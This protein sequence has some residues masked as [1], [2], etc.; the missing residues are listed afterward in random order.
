MGGGGMSADLHHVDTAVPSRSRSGTGRIQEEA[1]A[2]ACSSA[3][4]EYSP[5]LSCA[6]YTSRSNLLPLPFR[7]SF[8][9]TQSVYPLGARHSPP[10]LCLENK[11]TRKP[12]IQGGPRKADDL[13]SS[14]MIVN[15]R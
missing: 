8:V 11:L 15:A 9:K 5:K 12:I 7:I 13:Y 4:R 6:G 1:N 2:A 10:F 14:V 3:P